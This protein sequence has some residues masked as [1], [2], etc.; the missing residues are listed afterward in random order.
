VST[1][2]RAAISTALEKAWSGAVPDRPWL[3]SLPVSSAT[4]QGRVAIGVVAVNLAPSPTQAV[5]LAS[6]E[7]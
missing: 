3:A 7:K 5:A 6:T 4:D 1:L 2:R